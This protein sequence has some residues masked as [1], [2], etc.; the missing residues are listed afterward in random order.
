MKPV[1]QTKFG[2]PRFEG[3]CDPDWLGNCTQAVLASLLELD[4]DEVP[5]FVALGEDRWW[6]A[7]VSWLGE[8]GLFPVSIMP[9]ENRD[10]PLAQFTGYHAM[11]GISPRGSRHV[12]VGQS[13][14]LIH[15][16]RPEGGGLA[17]VESWWLFMAIDAAAI[18]KPSREAVL[19]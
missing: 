11:A 2:L 8:R 17:E 18:F 9:P 6:N 14:K 13:G 3:D 16:P 4:I 1:Y 15:D 7:M 12:V 19:T 5:H 10:E